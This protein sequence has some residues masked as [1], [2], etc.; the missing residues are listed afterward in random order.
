LK[1]SLDYQSQDHLA[2]VENGKWMAEREEAKKQ[3]INS[4][5]KSHGGGLF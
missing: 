1:S 5:F 3:Q 4:R 2:L